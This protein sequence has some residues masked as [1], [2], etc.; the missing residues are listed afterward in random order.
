MLC[1]LGCDVVIVL[2]DDLHFVNFKPFTQLRG[3]DHIAKEHA[4]SAQLNRVGCLG[5]R[6]L[7]CRNFV[8]HCFQTEQQLFALAKAKPELLEVCVLE[9]RQNRHV[10][11][12]RSQFL[13]QIREVGLL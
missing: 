8:R 7:R 11:I 12:F 2:K 10:D 3:A 4:Q 1:D 9:Q 13:V 6:G 5:L